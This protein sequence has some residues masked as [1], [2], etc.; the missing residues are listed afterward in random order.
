MKIMLQKEYED[1][2]DK[3]ESYFRMEAIFT[4]IGKMD[5]Q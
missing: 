3:S 5:L 4:E 1:N 2:K